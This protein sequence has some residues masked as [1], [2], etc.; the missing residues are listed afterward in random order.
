MFGLH[1]HV[2]VGEPDTALAVYNALRGYL[3]EIAAL[4]GNAPFY[5][6][7][8]TGLASVRPKICEALPRQGVPPLI[9]SWDAYAELLAWGRKA[10]SVPDAKHLWWE[11]RLHPGHG[12]LEVRAPDAQT[13]L[14]EVGALAAVVQA[15]VA[16]LAA[17]HEAGEQLPVAPSV[18]IAEN[19]WS[20]LRHGL[21][22][23]LADLSSGEPMPTR[24]RVATVLDEIAPHASWLGTRECLVQAREMLRTSG[25]ERQRRIAAE[26][27]LPALVS[28]LADRFVA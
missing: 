22:G 15:L 20:A 4:A 17:R 23:Q 1:V 25:A 7:R 10:G 21:D 6:A 19:R 28:R 9:E 11:L 24:D 3:P 8:D 27:G 13:H 2:A 14:W 18:R 26:V 16:S 5:G 12:T